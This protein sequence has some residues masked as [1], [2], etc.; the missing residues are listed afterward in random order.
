MAIAQYY[1]NK[2]IKHILTIQF[3]V[4]KALR[5]TVVKQEGRKE[6]EQE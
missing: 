6:W 2:E 4:I 5:V 3:L 1:Y